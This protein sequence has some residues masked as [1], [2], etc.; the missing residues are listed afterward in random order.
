MMQRNNYSLISFFSGVGL[1]DLGLEKSG[2][3][4]DFINE[5]YP[6]FIEAN[7]F[8]RKKMKLADPYY[9]YHCGDIKSFLGK[10]EE[11]LIEITSDIRSRKNILG[12]VGGPPCPDFS[13]GGKNKGQHGN[14]GKLT[15]DYIKVI[16]KHKPEFFIFENVKGLWRTKR[17]REFYESLKT[18]LKKG[19]YVIYDDLLNSIEYGVPQDRDRIIMFGIY[20]DTIPSISETCLDMVLPG[21]IF[22]FNP[23]KKYAGRKAFEYCWP[24]RNLFTGEEKL[25]MSNGIPKNLTIEYWFKKNDVD[26]HANSKHYFKPRVGLYRFQTVDEGDVSRKSYKRP[27][28]WRYSPT[29]CYGNNEVH[30]HPYKER[31]LTAAETLAIQSMPRQF[32]LPK[33]MSLT[34][35]FKSIGNGVPYLMS[36]GIARP[37]L[38]FMEKYAYK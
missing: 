30:L 19:G 14:N 16:L 11:R 37:I 36:K 13:V 15:L 32:V 38:N 33:E 22:N 23:I 26:N 17:H 24:T 1:L 6:P 8:S 9:G 12:M 21:N 35:M 10:D 34:N 20:K 31:R 28:R 5:I 25:P 27:H 7:K 2:F 4:I 18:K 29:A 3:S